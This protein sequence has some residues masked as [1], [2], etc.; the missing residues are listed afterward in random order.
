MSKALVIAGFAGIGKTYLANKCKNVAD[1][2]SS[3]YHYDYSNVDPS[4][5]EKMK[6]NPNRVVNPDFP[7]NY[8]K[9]I[10]KAIKKYDIVFI[11]FQINNGFLQLCEQNGIDYQICI[12]SREA[13]KN[14]KKRYVERG[15]SERWL[16][17]IEPYYEK[18]LKYLESDPH[19]KIILEP[20][21]TIEDWLLKNGYKLE[22]KNK[23]K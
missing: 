2:E 23:K 7:Q 22:L 19:K 13:F 10:K 16:S 15:N 6:G 4:E 8:I 3:E 20:D 18:C 9:A 17:K 11:W 14:Y 21:E 12:P 1:L 5:Y